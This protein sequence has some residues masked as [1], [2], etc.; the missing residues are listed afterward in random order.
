MFMIGLNRGIEEDDIYSVTNGMR[1]DQNTQIFERLW[2][3]ELKKK[4]PSILR[5]MLKIHGFKVITLSI[6]F[7][8]GVVL[9]R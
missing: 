8:V 2:Q 1:S 9:A 6:L 4:N 3:L 5:V 7:S